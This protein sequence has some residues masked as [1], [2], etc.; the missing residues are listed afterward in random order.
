MLHDIRTSV[1][2]DSTPLRWGTDVTLHAIRRY[3]RQVAERFH[4]DQIILFGSHAYGALNADSDVDLLVVMPT[5]NPLDQ[6][7]KIRLAIPAPFPL[8]LLVRTPETLKWRLEEGD[9]F[10][11]EIVSRGKVLY[12]KSHGRAGGPTRRTGLRWPQ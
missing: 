11:R 7:L 9:C 10:L 2:T 8:D 5:R 3:A 12:E 1:T 6:A 4:P